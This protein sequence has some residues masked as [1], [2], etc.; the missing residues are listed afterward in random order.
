MRQDWRGFRRYWSPVAIGLRRGR[1]PARG[2]RLSLRADSLHGRHET[3][4]RSLGRS[5]GANSRR[6]FQRQRVDDSRCRRRGDASS[7]CSQGRR[8]HRSAGIVRAK[9]HRRTLE[10]VGL[11][12][13]FG[14]GRS[15]RRSGPVVVQERC[16]SQLRDRF[17]F[18][19]GRLW[20]AATRE[21]RR[22]QPSR[23]LLATDS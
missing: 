14:A 21:A 12:E 3:G 7:A 10:G 17:G 15:M 6:N 1:R 5:A 2:G 20:T 16:L 9:W 4:A 23:L 18:G 11:P 8:Q 19:R 13:H 22:R